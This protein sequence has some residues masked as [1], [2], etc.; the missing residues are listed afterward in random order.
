MLWLYKGLFWVWVDS[1]RPEAANP[2]PGATL[3][4]LHLQGAP[5]LPH[6][7]PLAL[8]EARAVIRLLG[9]EVRVHK[10]LTIL[11]NHHSPSPSR[12]STLL[13]SMRYA[14][15]LVRSGRA[16]SPV[17]RKLL[18]LGGTGRYLILKLCPLI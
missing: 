7:D 11:T 14:K 10:H 3:P 2:L 18:G 16:V 17:T 15:L 6:Q 5:Q 1:S 8:V 13:T 9:L 12:S 4:H